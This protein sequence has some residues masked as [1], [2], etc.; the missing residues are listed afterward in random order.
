MAILIP[1]F[2]FDNYNPRDPWQFPAQRIVRFAAEMYALASQSRTQCAQVYRHPDQR[3]VIFHALSGLSHS[4]LLGAMHMRSHGS[5]EAWWELQPEFTHAHNAQLMASGN[6]ALREMLQLG[7][8]QGVLRQADMAMRQY[9]AALQP[10]GE[11]P[12]RVASQVHWQFVLGQCEALPYLP[13]LRL[14]QIYRDSLSQMARFCA[15]DGKALQVRYGTRTFRLE[16]NAAID[17]D[18]LG[19][20]DDWDFLKFL[21]TEL[22]QMLHTLHRSPTLT[23]IA[24]IATSYLD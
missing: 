15:A 17:Y 24:A 12:Q 18:A 1:S 2:D 22:D 10:L 11:Q 20:I 16:A 19:F 4:L 5:D 7:Y 6:M 23:A 8:V 21:M 13:L 9:A 14:F 3:F